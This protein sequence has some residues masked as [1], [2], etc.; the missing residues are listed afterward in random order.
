MQLPPPIHGV[1]VIN[2]TVANSELLSARFD[3][4]V[5]PLAFAT[6]FEELDRFTLRKLGRLFQT[7]ARLAHALVA[8]R[9]HAVYF[10][11]APTG[12]AFYRDC[13]LI[14]IMKLA[15]VSRIY[16]LHGTAIRARLVARWRRRL[17]RWAF[18]DAWVIH[19]SERLI[20][21]LHDLVPPGRV[22][23]VPNG[24]SEQPAPDRA[25][26]RGHTRL[27]YLSNMTKTKGALVLIEALGLLRARGIAFTATFAGA[28]HEDEFMDRCHAE[29]RRCGLEE[30]VRYVGPAY[31]EHKRRLL[32]E[33][34][35]FVL[36]TCR[37]AFPLVALEAMQAG[38]PVVTTHEGA[39]PEIIED[40]KTGLLVPAGDP[41][42]L[43]GCLATL[44][45]DPGMQRRMGA[46]GRARCLENYTHT[47]FEQNLAA[48]L[49]V[50]MES[51]AGRHTK[52]NTIAGDTQ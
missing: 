47:V 19:L 35:V 1:T 5:L 32:E 15:G 44:I 49:A 23:V 8:R 20:A 30:H 9:P 22:L 26:R 37:D 31:D 43:A 18:R 45:A 17:Y 48:A 21:D 27:L 39:L 28:V 6:S 34:D 16:H 52:A 36:P 25:A 42:A 24:V 51:S 2:Q 40:G 10:T 14:A 38:L 13:L 46:S 11:V 33:H 41:G 50:C 29:I 3:I 7:S 12:A 4:E